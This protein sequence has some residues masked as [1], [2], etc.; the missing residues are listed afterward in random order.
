VVAEILKT[1]LDFNVRIDELN[2]LM[3]L[4]ATS[5]NHN[6]DRADQ[7]LWKTKELNARTMHDVDQVILAAPEERATLKDV[8]EP[9]AKT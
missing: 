7:A 5:A 4:V 6:L 1:A 9:P 8:L 3:K 2:H